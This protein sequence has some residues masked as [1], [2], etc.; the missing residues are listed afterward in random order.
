MQMAS[1]ADTVVMYIPQHL[2]RLGFQR[3]VACATLAAIACLA[4][5][6][7][8]ANRQAWVKENN[9]IIDSVAVYPGAIERAPRVTHE[10]TGG[11]LLRA[12]GYDTTATFTLPAGVDSEN[13]SSYYEKHLPGGWP[14]HSTGYAAI[15]CRPGKALVSIYFLGDPPLRAYHILV[16]K[17]FQDDKDSST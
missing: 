12:Q 7:G 10:I 1:R 17:G 8:G 2:H 6:C 14:C 4:T 9:R 5:A 16:D 13:L 15:E 11:L 3:L